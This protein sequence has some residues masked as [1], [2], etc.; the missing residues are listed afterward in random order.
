[1][2][3]YKNTTLFLVLVLIILALVGLI[4]NMPLPYFL[5]P[6]FV[7]LGILFYGSAYIN[8]G[9]FMKVIS[10]GDKTI[11]EVAITFDDGPA[12]AST[13]EILDILKKND[14]PATFFCIGH[15]VIENPELLQRIASEGHLV[16]NHSYSHAFFFD[17]FSRDNMSRE[18]RSTNR[19]VEK[20]TRKRMFFFRPPYGV[21]TPVL[22]KAVKTANVTPIGWSLRTMDTVTKSPEKLVAKINQNIKAGDIILLHDTQQVT[23][24]AL[25]Q[26]IE[27]IRNKGFKIVR[28]DKLINMNGHA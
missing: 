6:V 20:L 13:P 14:T 21:T 22:A 10:S 5:I 16:G 15:K 9:F 1:M 19:A 27:T 18:I 24:D 2:L 28:L 3:N 23:V 26:I 8:S 25:P 7:Y 17:L 11:P 12:S 4:N